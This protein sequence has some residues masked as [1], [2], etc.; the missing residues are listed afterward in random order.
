MTRHTKIHLAEPT[1]PLESPLGRIARDV[2]VAVAEEWLVEP[3]L[4]C[5]RERTKR[6]ACARRD[7]W[8][9]LSQKGFAASEI[10]VLFSRDHTTVLAGLKRAREDKKIANEHP[11]KAP[12]KTAGKARR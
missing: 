3:D 4:L 7:L 9:R 6:I 11:V 2:A 8:W 12:I 10:A 5:S 1:P